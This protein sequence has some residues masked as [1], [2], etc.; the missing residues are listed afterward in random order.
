MTNEQ[1]ARAIPILTAKKSF[2]RS[3]CHKLPIPQKRRLESLNPKPEYPFRERSPSLLC[4]GHDAI[5]PA[6]FSILKRTSLSFKYKEGLTCMYV[7]FTFFP[8]NACLL[9][10]SYCIYIC[11]S[12]SYNK[13]WKKTEFV[14]LWVDQ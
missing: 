5:L 11:C 13:E 9:I 14:D 6:I 3:E 7:A 8:I 4:S 1:M 12:L 2:R 10:S